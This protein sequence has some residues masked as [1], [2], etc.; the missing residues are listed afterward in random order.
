MDEILEPLRPGRAG[1]MGLV[2]G[3]GLTTKEYNTF[4]Q[5]EPTIMKQHRDPNEKC[6]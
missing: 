1:P 4:P 2:L 3:L 6:Y 5:Q